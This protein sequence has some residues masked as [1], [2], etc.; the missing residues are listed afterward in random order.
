MKQSILIAALLFLVSAKSLCGTKILSISFEKNGGPWLDPILDGMRTNLS[1]TDIEIDFVNTYFNGNPKFIHDQ[2]LTQK[3]NICFFPDQYLLKMFHASC[4]TVKA[5]VVYVS[6]TKPNT[7]INKSYSGIFIDFPAN[8]T[9]EIV[10]KIKPI[11]SFGIIGGSWPGAKLIASEIKEKIGSKATAE[12]YTTDKWLEYKNK[13]NSWEKT[14]DSIWVLIPFGVYTEN[15]SEIDHSQVSKL[16]ASI[17]VPTIG[18]GSVKGEIKRTF[19]IGP[20]PL[21]IGKYAAGKI[22]QIL[23]GDKPDLHRFSEL[24]FI[25][26]KNSLKA[27]GLDKKLPSG[28]EHFLR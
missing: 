22:Y 1:Y 28:F 7:N 20:D 5:K 26:D 24:E 6:N 9:F 11:K 14:K 8:K 17:K 2:I 16:I 10:N 13:I 19:N 12:I 4:D 15:D 21:K 27:I 23:K 18:F 25:I 3:P